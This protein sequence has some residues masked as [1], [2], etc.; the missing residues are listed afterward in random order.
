VEG[1]FGPGS[2]SIDILMDEVD[3]DGTESSIV[4][5]YHDGWGVHNCAHGED[6]G[7]QCF[8]GE[9]GQDTETELTDIICGEYHFI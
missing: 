7:V 8:Y 3:C 6:A 9:K 5:C 2:D 4:E 1:Y